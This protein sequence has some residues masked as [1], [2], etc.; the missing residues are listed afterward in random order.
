[1]RIIICG[2]TGFVGQAMAHYLRHIEHRVEAL[3]I[4]SSTSIDSIIELR[5]QMSLLISLDPLF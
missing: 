1:M 4:R 2:M 5:V 3:S